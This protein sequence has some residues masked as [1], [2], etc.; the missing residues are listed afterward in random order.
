M[1]FVCCDDA[2]PA[3]HQLVLALKTLCAFSVREIGLR[4]FITEATV[5]QRLSRARRRLQEAQPELDAIAPAQLQARFPAVQ[6]ILYLMFTE[7]YLAADADTAIRRDLCDEA[8]R[9]AGVLIAHPLGRTPES[10]ALLALMHLH[11]A[12]SGGREGLSGG[13]LLLQEQDRSRWDREEIGRG[14][15]WLAESANG[16]VF[17]RYHAEAGI[18][19]EHCLAPSFGETRWDRVVACYELL[20]AAAPSPLHRLNRAVAVAEWKGPADGLAILSGTE[21]PTWLVGSYLWSSVLADLHRRCGHEDAAARYRR[22]ALAS[23]PSAAVRTLLER[24]LGP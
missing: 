20:E 6:R 14:L 17:S 12:R 10:A 13:L 8:V 7:G 15:S 11:Q 24:R 1:L 2:L 9:L 16:A 18:A 21:P 4:L 19:A 22:V 23:A 3:E 5:H